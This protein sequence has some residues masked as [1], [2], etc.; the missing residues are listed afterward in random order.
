MCPQAKVQGMAGMYTRARDRRGEWNEEASKIS[1]ER[2]REMCI[3]STY[4]RQKPLYITLLLLILS[5]TLYY[6]I[7]T[8]GHFDRPDVV[9]FWILLISNQ[10]VILYCINIQSPRAFEL[11][12]RY[13]II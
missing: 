12:G 13:K 9:L 11:S 10:Y 7:L 1:S 6:T 3:P 5:I 4:Q 2:G 8:V